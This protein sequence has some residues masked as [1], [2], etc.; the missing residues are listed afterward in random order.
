MTTAVQLLELFE[1]YLKSHR[2]PYYHSTSIY[3]A[4][5]ILQSNTLGKITYDYPEYD[6][7]KSPRP[8][9]VSGPFSV[10]R[11]PQHWRT[12]DVKFELDADKLHHNYKID[13]HLDKF[14]GHPDYPEIP[15]GGD[16]KLQ[17]TS[18][19]ESEA[20]IHGPVKNINKYIKTIHITK[21]A[22]KELTDSV[23]HHLSQVNHYKRQADLYS[24]GMFEPDINRVNSHNS[25]RFRIPTVDKDTKLKIGDIV[26]LPK[27]WEK[28]YNT[29]SANRSIEHHT[30][31]AKMDQDILNHPKL[32]VGKY[33]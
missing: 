3:N 13:P 19:W 18:R 33:Y 6:P 30:K 11:D 8:K 9:I 32:V 15:I 28:S 22:H 12:N 7:V 29:E 27:G 16:P 5:D 26:P 31:Y 17:A 4:K 1:S 25:G 20:L 21:N 14:I 10:S 24:M 2:A 23:N